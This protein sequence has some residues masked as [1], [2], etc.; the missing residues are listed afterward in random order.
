MVHRL[1]L[2]PVA[3]GFVA[4]LALWSAPPALAHDRPLDDLG[5][6]KDRISTYYHC[7][8]GELKGRKFAQKTGARRALKKLHKQQAEAAEQ[9]RKDAEDRKVMAAA[10]EMKAMVSHMKEQGQAT[11]VADGFAPYRATLV[12][13]ADVASIELDVAVWPG[14]TRRTT[15]QLAGIIAPSIHGPACGKSDAAA[16]RGFVMGWLAGG[17]LTV[18][19]VDGKGDRVTGHI[20]KNGNDL[21]DALVA[22]GLA[23]EGQGAWCE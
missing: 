23:K 11:N 2:F 18:L 6:H 3:F 1:N 16:A 19:P 10:A 5:C 14:E 4:I 13:V 8:E 20:R 15:V 12:A 21:G 9:A 22:A 17:A 7:H